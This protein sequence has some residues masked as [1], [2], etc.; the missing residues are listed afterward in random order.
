MSVAAPVNQLPFMVTEKMCE[1][2]YN[3]NYHRRAAEAREARANWQKHW[4]IPVK[5]AGTDQFKIGLML[6]DVQ[7]TFCYPSGELYVGG[8]DGRASVADS[9]RISNW[10]LRNLPYITN[11]NCTLDTHNAFQIFHESFFICNSAFTDQVTKIN[12]K[13]GDHPAPFT[14]ITTSQVLNGQWSVNPEVAWA[15]TGNG[16]SLMA[17][18]KHVEHYVQELARQGKYSLTIW[19]YHAMLG[20][21]NHA[22]VSGI[23]EAIFF[24]SIARGSQPNFEVKGGNSLTENYSVLRPEVMAS[25]DG[26]AFAQ[27]N[28]KFI[29][30]L[31]RYDA[32]FIGGQAKSHCVAWTIDDLLNEIKTKDESLAKKVWLLEDC[33]SPVVI[34]GVYDYTND[35]NA[36]F[37]RFKAAGMNVVASTDHLPDF[38]PVQG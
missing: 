15:I 8:S 4:S 2:S 38:L 37:D 33:T 7:G 23:E 21:A 16:A 19:P 32:L 13:H 35:A 24:H 6:I 14:F 25:A 30:N 3:V 5:P 29:E 22:L 10:I 17:V 9:C 20:S 18:Q 26:R 31:L 27:K 11:T 12:Y 1:A 34:P 28:T 36:A